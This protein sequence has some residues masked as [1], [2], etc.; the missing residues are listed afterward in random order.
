MRTTISDSYLSH[1]QFAGATT[2]VLESLDHHTRRTVTATC[3]CE[4]RGL[5]GRVGAGV[6]DGMI[7]LC[8]AHAIPEDG[9]V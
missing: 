5:V 9:D 6:S 1:R 2:R 4:W 7:A 3:G 8:E